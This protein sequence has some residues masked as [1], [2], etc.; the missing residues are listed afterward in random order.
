MLGFSRDIQAADLE[1]VRRRFIRAGRRRDR[2]CVVLPP[3]RAGADDHDIHPAGVEPHPD[4][5]LVDQLERIA[6]KREIASVA[7]D[8]LVWRIVLQ[9]VDVEAR[10]LLDLRIGE[11]GGAIVCNRRAEQAHEEAQVF[12]LRAE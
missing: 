2:P 5:A 3:A 1:V 10:R 4:A 8:L 11:V 9:Q 7:L 6:T 12:G